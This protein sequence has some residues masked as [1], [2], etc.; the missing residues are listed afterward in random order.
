MT[1]YQSR[2]CSLII[3]ESFGELTE[4]VTSHL[5]KHGSQKLSDIT[6]SLKI[7]KAEVN[8]TKIII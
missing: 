5:M 8:N 7:K 6:K 3:E 2:V 1:Q 4:K